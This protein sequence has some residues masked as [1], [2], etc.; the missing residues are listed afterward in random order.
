MRLDETYLHEALRTGFRQGAAS[1]S[2]YNNHIV[3]S[4]ANYQFTRELSFRAIVDYNGVLPN[5]SLAA[6]DRK[7]RVSYD[8]LFTYLV[9]PGTAFYAGY[10][11]IYENY[12]FNPL[13]QPYLSPSGSPNLNTGRQA[14]V[15]LSYLFRF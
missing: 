15:K 5:A 1:A 13:Q 6:L 11:D 7:K 12:R 9:H 3:R 10:T 4:K 2:V 14:F 8:F